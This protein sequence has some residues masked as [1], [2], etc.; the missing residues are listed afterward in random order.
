M[1]NLP[2]R[3]TAKELGLKKLNPNAPVLVVPGRASYVGG[4][5]VADVVASGMAHR[6]GASLLIDVGT[7]GEVVLGNKDWL[8]ACSAAAGP[9]FEG[10]RS[11]TG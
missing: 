6:E 2:P 8:L 4:D 3:L 9:A 7:N 1:S 11:A 5:V 10:A